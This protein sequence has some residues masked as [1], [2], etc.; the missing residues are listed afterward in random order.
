[1]SALTT[2]LKET[3]TWKAIFQGQCAFR[4]SH[5]HTGNLR[6][7]HLFTNTS[8]CHFVGCPIVQSNYVAIQ[9]SFDTIYLVTKNQ[10]AKISETWS[11][12][13]LPSNK[14]EALK[15]V[16]EAIANLNP[17]LKEAVLSKFDHLY[18]ISVVI[19]TGEETAEASDEDEDKDLEDT[20]EE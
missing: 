6:C 13:E 9:R 19:R 14:D 11:D 18:N 17:V 20:K 3:A 10:N 16:T 15:I 2:Q 8:E 5:A 1:M 12:Q 7:K 4:T